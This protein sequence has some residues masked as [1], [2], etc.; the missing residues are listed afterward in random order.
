[1]TLG[2]AKR[3][4]ARR[5]AAVGLE[6]PDADARI[7]T[8]ALMQLDRTGF[9]REEMRPLAADEAARL[10]AA[11]VRRL[12]REPVAHIVGEREFW[13]LPIRVTGATL[14]PRPETET[15][16]ETALGLLAPQQR[17]Q[18]L[19]IADLGTGS[20]AI[21]LALL[22]ELPRAFGVGTDL[23]TAALAT[24]TSNAARLELAARARFVACDYAA[25]LGGNLDL[26]VSNPPYVASADIAKLMPEVRDYDPHLALDGGADGLAAY[27]ALAL[28]AK[29]V[30][31]PMGVLVV[32]IG[33]DQ[34]SEVQEIFARQDWDAS[35]APVRD[36]SGLAR[37]IV[38]RPATGPRT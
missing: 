34:A 27:R 30:L 1:M 17:S 20:G 25:A 14:V 11:A 38:V 19:N 7:L 5:F 12:A 13:S 28:D 21:L 4:L 9:M 35:A 29:R 8:Q 32:E 26:V 22:S 10:E 16:V 23:S 18:Q 36:L 37:V 31:R 6:S 24:A 2:E 15:V 3:L 33:A